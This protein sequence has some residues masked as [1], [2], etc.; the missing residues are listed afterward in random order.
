MCAV[1]VVRRWW[2]TRKMTADSERPEH[3]HNKQ[4]AVNQSINISQHR[5]IT[6][7]GDHNTWK[8]RRYIQFMQLNAFTERECWQIYWQHYYTI[9]SYVGKKNGENVNTNLLRK[10][11][12]SSRRGILSPWPTNSSTSVHSRVGVVSSAGSMA[13]SLKLRTHNIDT[14]NTWLQQQWDVSTSS[15]INNI[16]M[17]MLFMDIF[18]LHT[19]ILNRTS[20]ED[21]LESD[22]STLSNLTSTKSQH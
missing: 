8:I 9:T 12:S 11:L 10:V 7:P 22:L 21:W 13:P 5:I 18:V 4:A 14:V 15:S 19:N 3:L 6:W 20:C 17:V 16:Q 2:A 1:L